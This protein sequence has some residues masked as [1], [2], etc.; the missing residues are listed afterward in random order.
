MSP[1]CQ[2]FMTGIKQRICKKLGKLR[3]DADPPPQMSFPRKERDREHQGQVAIQREFCLPPGSSG[4]R[5]TNNRMGVDKLR[6]LSKKKENGVTLGKAVIT[7]VYSKKRRRIRWKFQIKKRACC[8]Q[9]DGFCL[10][11]QRPNLSSWFLNYSRRKATGF[12]LSRIP[13]Q[14][15]IS[16]DSR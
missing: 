4:K 14:M 13:I 3:E 16:T 6:K 11:R 7:N 1:I 12:I 9:P 5:T 10:I 15:Q 2:R 8:F